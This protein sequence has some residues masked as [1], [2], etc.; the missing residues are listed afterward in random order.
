MEYLIVSTAV[1]DQISYPNTKEKILS[2]G[3]AGF[4]AYSGARIW[5][6]SVNLVCGKGKD[7]D[8]V[9]KPYFIKDMISDQ[10]MFNLDLPT[11]T[12]KVEYDTTGERVETPVYGST[13][14]QK[15]V[16]NI[17]EI[18]QHCKTIKGLYIFKEAEDVEFW[19]KLIELKNKYNFKI[20][21]EI[22]SDS[23][24]E[25]NLDLIKRLSKNIDVFSINKKEAMSLFNCEDENLEE[26]FKQFNFDLVFF[27]KGAK[28]ASLI[29]KREIVF[30]PSCNKF[31]LI[32]PTGAGNSSSAA[33]LVG[34]CE[35]KSLLE[36]GLMGSI[37]AGF[38][39]SQNGAPLTHSKEITEKAHKLLNEELKGKTYVR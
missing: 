8:T 2:I 1:V 6:K 10:C 30:A 7:F 29:S 13:H 11:P 34:Y 22:S 15:F 14:Y 9:I 27:R 4:Y 28:G 18:E 19:E 33:V 21:W 20:L 12:T 17:E 35:N 32:D 24:K 23:T 38:I 39:I 37:S 36:I 25:S 31:A 3:G 16:A 26:R 5:S